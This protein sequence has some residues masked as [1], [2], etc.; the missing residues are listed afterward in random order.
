[1][2]IT[3]YVLIHDPTGQPVSSSL[4]AGSSAPPDVIISAKALPCVGTATSMVH[5]RDLV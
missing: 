5:T 1:M 2:I 3:L 4:P